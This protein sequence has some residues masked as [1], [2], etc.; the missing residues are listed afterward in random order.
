LLDFNDVQLINGARCIIEDLIP[1]GDR[2]RGHTSLTGAIDAQLAVK[3]DVD[4]TIL[5]TLELMKDGPEGGMMR[6]VLDV[7]EVGIDPYG[8]PLTSCVSAISTTSPAAPHRSR[9]SCRPPPSWPSISWQEPSKR[10]ASR[11]RPP[12]MSPPGVGACRHQEES[13]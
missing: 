10:P 9:R 5:V 2:P 4:K 7:V 11:Y 8:K 3:R 1:K 12:I 6:M 13:L